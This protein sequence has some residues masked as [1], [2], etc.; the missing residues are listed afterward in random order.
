MLRKDD[1]KE[2]DGGDLTIKFFLLGMV[3]SFQSIILLLKEISC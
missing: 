2:G 1:K 3:L